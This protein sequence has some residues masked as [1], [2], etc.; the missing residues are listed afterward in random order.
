M[1]EVTL[2]AANIVLFY[3]YCKY[4]NTNLSFWTIMIKYKVI[5]TYNVNE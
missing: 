4:F 2:P 1:A 3:E 5:I